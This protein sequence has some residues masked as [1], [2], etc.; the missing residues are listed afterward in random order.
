MSLVYMTKDYSEAE[1]ICYN[2]GMKIAI[3]LFI[4]FN[5]IEADS[6]INSLLDTNAS[7]AL[8]SVEN[9]YRAP[10]EDEKRLNAIAGTKKRAIDDIAIKVIEANVSKSLSVGVEYAP[11]VK[12]GELIDNK[13]N[14]EITLD[15]KF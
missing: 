3:I 10:S 8:Y 4:I 12:H 1:I 5:H 7:Q 2:Q 15:Y 9:G 13:Q 14:A 6:L 11:P